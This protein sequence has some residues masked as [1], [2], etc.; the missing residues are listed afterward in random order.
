MHLD[1]SNAGDLLGTLSQEPPRPS[2][3]DVGRAMREGRRRRRAR[4][5]AL[6]S[7]AAGFTALALAALPI[8]LRSIGT[9]KSDISERT[10]TSPSVAASAAPTA[11]P[12]PSASASPSKAPA[13]LPTSCTVDRLPIPDNVP[14]SIVTAAD[15]TGRLVFGRSYPGNGTQQVLLWT[16]GKASKVDVP[17][18]DQAMHSVNAA[19]VAVGHSYVDGEPVAWLYRDGRVSELPAGRSAEAQGI[20]ASNVIVGERA[21]RPVRWASPTAEPISLEVPPDAQGGAARAVDDDG[22]AV[23]YVYVGTNRVA[24][25]WT[26]D[27]KG[28]PLASGDDSAAFTVRNGWATGLHGSSGMRW[29]LHTGAAESVPGMQIRPS[30]ANA[31]GW[32]V[33]TD[34]QGR[35][36]LTGAGTSVRLPDLFL[37]KADEFSNL[38]ET[39]SDDGRVIAGQANDAAGALYAAV[40]HCR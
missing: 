30:T 35:G 23:G 26:P 33:G 18:D 2:S 16:N 31:S 5:A 13:R 10:S 20:N 8:G 6:T 19:G 39:L 12:S 29:N 34:P 36:V 37:H 4:R 9:S 3:I 32:M 11:A 7:G 21:G 38:P 14:K 28:R 15:P 25:A 27:G 17:G 22:T 1:E 40:W 24:Y